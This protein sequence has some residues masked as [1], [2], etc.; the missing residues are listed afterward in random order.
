MPKSHRL[1][2]GVKKGTNWDTS[3]DPQDEEV[4]IEQN[5]LAAKWQLANETI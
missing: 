2:E 3:Q 4:S 5:L 1:R